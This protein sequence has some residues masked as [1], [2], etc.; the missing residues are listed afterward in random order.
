MSFSLA[1]EVY[2]DPPSSTS[3]AV[4][5]ARVNPSLIYP[6]HPIAIDDPLSLSDFPNSSEA[7]VW[8]HSLQTLRD[9]LQH[10]FFRPGDPT[11]TAEGEPI[12]SR[13]AW[14]RA[15]SQILMSLHESLR[16][17]H[18]QAPLTRYFLELS[19][20]EQIAFNLFQTCLSSF[21]ELFSNSD[22]FIP[23][24]RYLCQRCLEQCHIARAISDEDWDAR[25]RECGMNAHT[26][27]LTIFNEAIRDFSK[28]ISDWLDVQRSTALDAATLSVTSSNPPPFDADPRLV[29]WSNWIA[30]NLKARLMAE[31]EACARDEVAPLYAARLEALNVAG[32]ARAT[33]P[34]EGIVRETPKSTQPS[35][36]AEL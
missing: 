9:L 16:A 35:P 25:L 13:H 26:A 24:E 5:Q 17:S 27:K 28:E 30:S 33:P 12:P 1:P 11:T 2:I 21:S 18:T 6:K 34:Q 29:E 3:T 4:I 10:G 36:K 14:L 31:A 19:E 22:N 23:G 8:L 15:S 32:E 7:N 20:D